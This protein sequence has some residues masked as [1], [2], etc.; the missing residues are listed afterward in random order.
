MNLADNTYPLWETTADD[1]NEGSSCVASISS[2]KQGIVY[3]INDLFF[4]RSQFRN[5]LHKLSQYSDFVNIYFPLITIQKIALQ[6]T[7]HIPEVNRW[8]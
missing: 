7:A 6:A 8:K 2:T 5:N 3:C 4:S 1:S